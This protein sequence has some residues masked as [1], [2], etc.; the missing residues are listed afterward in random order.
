MLLAWLRTDDKG[1][2]VFLQM[3]LPSLAVH[4]PLHRRPVARA[5]PVTQWR[6]RSSQPILS[7]MLQD[8]SMAFQVFVV[9]MDEPCCYT[10]IPVFVLLSETLRQDLK[11]QDAKD[12]SPCR[13]FMEL[14]VLVPCAEAVA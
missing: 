14:V 1:N 5:K 2:L 10:G 4:G 6:T 9:Y 3:L 12:V 13:L 8:Q 11:V 7:R